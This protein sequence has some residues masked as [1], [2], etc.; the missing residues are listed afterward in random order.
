M[1]KERQFKGLRFAG[2]ERFRATG[3]KGVMISCDVR[4][5]TMCQSEVGGPSARPICRLHPL[6]SLPP[7]RTLPL[8]LGK[9][10]EDLQANPKIS[11]A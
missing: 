4:S 1:F 8:P 3:V 11:C 5:E 2:F 6:S 7:S 9:G 10:D